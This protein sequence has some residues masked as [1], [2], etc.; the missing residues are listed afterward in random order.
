MGAPLPALACRFLA[1]G[2]D[3]QSMHNFHWI[4]VT[5]RRQFLLGIMLKLLAPV[6]ESYERQQACL[7]RV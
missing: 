5:H 2:E 6:A 7:A 4:L 3:H 1:V